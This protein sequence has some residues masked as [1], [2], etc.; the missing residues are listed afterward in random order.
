M[1]KVG[2]VRGSG[3]H[4]AIPSRTVLRLRVHQSATAPPSSPSRFLTHPA[5][6]ILISKSFGR[7]LNAGQSP[8][9]IRAIL[10]VRLLM[11][12]NAQGCQGSRFATAAAARR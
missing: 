2:E 7:S 10:Q 4:R 6:G 12:G 3:F 11:G 1:S 5:P 9:S 8:C